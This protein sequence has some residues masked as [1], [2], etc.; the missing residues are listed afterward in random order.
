MED[1]LDKTLQSKL[2]CLNA[3]SQAARDS[4]SAARE[5]GPLAVEGDPVAMAALFAN[6]VG[7]KLWLDELA[8]R[9]EG[10][11][12][13]SSAASHAARERGYGT[14][15]RV[16]SRF[17]ERGLAKDAEALRRQYTTLSPGSRPNFKNDV[18]GIERAILA[19]ATKALQEILERSPMALWAMDFS[20]SEYESENVLA[21]CAKYAPVGADVEMA[22]LFRGL[23]ASLHTGRISLVIGEA[24]SA[25]GV[26]SP[27]SPALMSKALLSCGYQFGYADALALWQRS[28]YERASGGAESTVTEQKI[29]WLSQLE[30]MGVSVGSQLTPAEL[31]SACS[32]LPEDP[33]GN[34]RVE[35]FLKWA[36][37]NGQAGLGAWVGLDM[38]PL[39]A[40]H[41]WK[42]LG[43]WLA[44]RGLAREAL[45]AARASG[46]VIT[47]ELVLPYAELEELR[48]EVGTATKPGAGRGELRL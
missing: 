17:L 7:L 12:V 18:Q 45:C 23:G 20:L 48:A 34:K 19:G 42:Q 2:A 27:K 29:A 43:P 26:G 5:N 32:E 41:A 39:R 21:F 8:G 15:E 16:G 25:S 44:D 11:A 6:P 38:S 14:G 9:C 4:L 37:E 28:R 22:A 31:K 33:T 46:A 36:Q 35:Q 10:D 47:Q 30:K 13:L 3:A 24:M 40:P 1:H